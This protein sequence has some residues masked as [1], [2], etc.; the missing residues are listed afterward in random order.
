MALTAL[1]TAAQRA[2]ESARPDRLLDDPLAATLAGPEGA[3]MMEVMDGGH[4]PSPTVAI[5]SR[6]FDDRLIARTCDGAR[7]IVLVGA[8]MDTRAFRLGLAADV[9]VFEI[10]QPDLLALKD[11]RLAR[12][13]AR[14]TCTRRAVGCDLAGAWADALR[15]SGFSTSEQSVFVAEGL[16]MYLD[17]AGVERLLGD[18]TPL[19]SPGSS[20]L[21]DVCGRSFRDSPY[22]TEWFAAMERAGMAW[23][24]GTDEPEALLA[25]HGW[26]ADVV[27]YGDEGAHFGR[28]T[29]P[30]VDRHNLA[31]PHSYLV[32]AI[33]LEQ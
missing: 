19:A 20:L 21:A 7:Q 16:L 18:L 27:R 5:R 11:E 24:F 3:R 26:Q 23:R 33:R 30:Q 4:Q 28:W 2:R 17:E 13:G 8:G 12:A 1:W 14:P 25:P 29:G 15:A 10:D 22:M 32:D 31:W 9:T 6:Y